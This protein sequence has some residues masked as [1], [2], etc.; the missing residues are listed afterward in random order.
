MKAKVLSFASIMLCSTAA[1]AQ[2]QHCW[3]DTAG[4]PD[5]K[6][7]IIIYGDRG[8]SDSADEKTPAR[9]LK[10]CVT[11]K[12]HKGVFDIWDEGREHQSLIFLYGPENLEHP[13]CWSGIATR[14]DFA[15]A[16]NDETKVCVSIVHEE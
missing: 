14:V 15:S 4:I 1:T 10:T 16:E 6:I 11:T 8:P 9:Y 2:E 3:G 13:T 5:M 7:P 12:G